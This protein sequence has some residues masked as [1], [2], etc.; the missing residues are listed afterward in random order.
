MYITQ[1]HTII[2]WWKLIFIGDSLSSQMLELGS[3]GLSFSLA[4]NGSVCTFS[5]PPDFSKPQLW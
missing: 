4:I 2:A 1:L 5:V 3:L